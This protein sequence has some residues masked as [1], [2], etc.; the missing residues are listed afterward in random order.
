VKLKLFLLRID[1]EEYRNNG[2][3][4][5]FI[6]S[7]RTMRDYFAAAYNTLFRQA[8]QATVRRVTMR[9]AFR[10]YPGIS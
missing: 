8:L 7:S 6:L 2:N 5:G 3:F 4:H 9:Y 10:Q 1:P